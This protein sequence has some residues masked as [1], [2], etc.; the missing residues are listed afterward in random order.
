MLLGRLAKCGFFVAGFV[1]LVGCASIVEGTDQ[2]IAIKTDPPEA[3][4][5]L[6]Q[7]GKLVGKIDKTP[8]T[9][10]LDKSKEDLVVEC[11]KEGH[12]KEVSN[13][14]SSF[15][16]MTFGNIIFGGI[17]G[18]GVDAASGAMHHY[19]EEVTVLLTPTSFDTEEDRDKF[20]SDRRDFLISETERSTT[21]IRKEC[22]PE[23]KDD[24]E[25]EVEELEEA[26]DAKLQLVE[27]RRASAIIKTPS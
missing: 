14:T 18:V 20:F 4:C 21:K 17:I 8:G 7:E 16:G 2:T 25:D 15:E 1:S 23:L 12:F 13:V 24:C 22:S 27:S 11:S 5:S 10:S 9:V 6:T 19:P 3:E 26:L